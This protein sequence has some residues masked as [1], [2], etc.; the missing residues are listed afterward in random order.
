MTSGACCRLTFETFT[1]SR[2]VQNFL[3][4]NRGG[5]RFEETAVAASVAYDDNG[6]ARAAMGI[7]SADF[8]NDGKISIAI[9][10][11]SEE[12][13]S[14]FTVSRRDGN[15]VLFADDANR[16]RIGGPTLL[17]LTFGLVMADMDLDGWCDLLLAN[18]H[19]EPSM[20]KL[21]PE[22]QYEQAPQLF[23]NLGETGRFADVS[24]DAGPA[25]Q[26][27]IVARGL[28]VGDLDGDGD[29]DV[30]ATANAGRAMVLRN[31]LTEKRTMLRVRLR[32]SGKNRDALG[33]VVT[34]RAGDLTQRRVARTG[35][36]YLSQ[37]DPALTFGLG[38][39]ASADVTVRWPDGVEQE[40][41]GLAARAEP[42][43]LERK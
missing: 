2:A 28:A 33:A 14:L 5:G 36:S 27:R 8:R 1:A 10:N 18:G 21:K 12:P 24:L 13:V 34:A 35:G 40:F 6:R 30:V 38:D 41:K 4:L 19:I 11:F 15:G 23:R 26:E 43:V 16:A 42:H 3:F 22:L 7:D 20:P 37:G 39:A 32:Q 31:D 25:F 9:G 17:P 29:L